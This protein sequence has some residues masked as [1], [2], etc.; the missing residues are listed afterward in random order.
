MT[1]NIAH[2][3]GAGLWPENT[4]GAFERAFA[5]GADG[6]EMDVQLS[7]DGAVVIFHDNALKPEI[8]R[9]ARGTWLEK[10]G[11]RISEL[12]LEELRAFDIGR[13]KPDTAY[14]ARAP[15]QEPLDGERI[16]L[17]RDLVVAAKRAGGKKLWIELK[18]PLMG[19]VGQEAPDLLA[20]AVLDILRKESALE[21]AT[22]VAFDWAGVIHA[23]KREPA[24]ETRCLTLPQ[25]WFAA[26]P[27]PAETGPPSA[28]NLNGLRE[29]L[30][31]GAPWEGGV[32]AK[33]HGGVLGAIAAARANG[34]Y[35]FHTDVTP[36]T[37]KEAAALGLDYAVWTV[38]ETDEM[39]RLLPLG[40]NGICTDRPDRLK[41]VLGI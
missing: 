10:T 12:T 13:L 39:R 5:L 11:P 23:K 7:K 30:A 24:C 21:L 33:D 16:P 40:C 29:M 19:G 8:V 35:A 20:D 25:S 18:T 41:A 34:W 26:D 38:N 3:G 2:R 37:A 36:E 27:P 28:S 14:A 17:L 22:L 32:H 15:E 4:M 6:V 31:R 1:L 9:D